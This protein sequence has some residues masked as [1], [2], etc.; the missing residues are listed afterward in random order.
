M[1]FARWVAIFQWP[2][3]LLS[4]QLQSDTLFSLRNRD[5]T[6]RGSSMHT[7]AQIESHWIY[8]TLIFLSM[9]ESRGQALFYLSLSGKMLLSKQNGVIL[10]PVS[11]RGSVGWKLYQ[12]Y[13]QKLGLLKRR[14]S[15]YKQSNLKITVLPFFT[16]FY[17]S[18][19]PLCSLPLESIIMF[20]AFFS[21]W[22]ANTSH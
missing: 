14:P 7:R 2:L 11:S 5:F 3:L 22:W 19:P 13:K 4:Q 8:L 10:K 6:G 21:P 9:T 20:S 15:S 1:C 16:L 18:L 12:L 17:P